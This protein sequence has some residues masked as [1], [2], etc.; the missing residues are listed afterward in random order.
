MTEPAT[1]LVVDDDWMNRELMEAALEA[2]GYNCLL[3]EDAEEGFEMAHTHQPDAAL[4]DVR[5]AGDESGYDLCQ[6]LKSTPSTQAIRVMMLTAFDGEADRR[7]AK[8][9]GADGFLTRGKGVSSILSAIE[10]LLAG[11]SDD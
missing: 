5:L 1:I 11:T 4:L 3:A 9:A 7:R 10:T 8:Q 6:K 2:G